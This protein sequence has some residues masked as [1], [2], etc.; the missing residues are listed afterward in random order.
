M[1]AAVAFN[2]LTSFLPQK[3]LTNEQ[4]RESEETAQQLVG[5]KRSIFAQQTPL[6]L[7]KEVQGLRALFD[8]VSTPKIKFHLP[9]FCDCLEPETF[10]ISKQYALF[11]VYVEC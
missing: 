10:G 6:A 1:G 5:A 4:I 2:L 8:E 7:A 3:A 11:L 9:G